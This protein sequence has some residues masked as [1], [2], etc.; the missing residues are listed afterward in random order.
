[1][2][3]TRKCTSCDADMEVGF[4]PTS[5]GGAAMF[6]AAW[7]PGPPDSDMTFWEKVRKGPGVKVDE[8]KLSPIYAHRC[9][10]CGLV[11]LYSPT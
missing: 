8:A 10:S 7:H 1:M 2:A 4:V 5:K 9:P 6:T 3:G 11:Q